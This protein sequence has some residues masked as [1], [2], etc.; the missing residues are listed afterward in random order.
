MSPH[1][2]GTVNSASIVNKTLDSVS[3]S[4]AAGKEIKEE[5]ETVTDEAKKTEIISK[6]TEEN[7]KPADEIDSGKE[8]KGPDRPTDL[9]LPYVI[10]KHAECDTQEKVCNE[11]TN[12][13]PQGEKE[14]QKATEL[15][16]MKTKMK[17]DE[18]SE[19]RSNRSPNKKSSKDDLCKEAKEHKSVKGSSAMKRSSSLSRLSLPGKNQLYLLLYKKK[20]KLYWYG[21]P[22]HCTGYRVTT[23]TCCSV[24]YFER[25]DVKS[26]VTCV[27]QTV[28]STRVFVL[29]KQKIKSAITFH[30]LIMM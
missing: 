5:E 12:S 30:L 13:K 25:L 10:Q 20:K 7:K 15:L 2:D 4:V 22:W 19:G 11:A 14:D 24:L 21:S 23:R 17:A 16:L 9:K 29:A 6:P 3:E 26:I 28:P 8:A 1:G 18:V 27:N